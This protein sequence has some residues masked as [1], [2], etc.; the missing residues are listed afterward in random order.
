MK[1]LKAVVLT[2]LLAGSVCAGNIQNGVAPAP[3]PTQTSESTEPTNV[4]EP[5]ETTDTA[6]DQTLTAEIL[7]TVVSVL[8]LI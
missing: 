8:G 7:L 4:V 3:T 6:T 2:L 1:L 5:T